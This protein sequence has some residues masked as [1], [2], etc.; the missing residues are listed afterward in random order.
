MND[1]EDC[2]SVL[3]EQSGIFYIVKKVKERTRDGSHYKV[4]QRDEHAV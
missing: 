3:T 1:L 4:A 2:E